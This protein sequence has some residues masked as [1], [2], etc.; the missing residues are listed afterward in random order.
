MVFF[1]FSFFFKFQNYT[2][3]FFISCPMK[4]GSN[5]F[6]I[7]KRGR[8]SY[9]SMTLIT[10]YNIVAN[11]TDTT[12]NVKISKHL[13]LAKVVYRTLL[14]CMYIRHGTTDSLLVSPLSQFNPHTPNGISYDSSPGI[15]GTG[16][17]K[18]LLIVNVQL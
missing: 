11:N 17:K 10:A 7:H 3:Y 4:N 2:L 5:F 1:W 14:S 6:Y 13:F 9:C 15:C 18:Y 16:V 8:V 12:R